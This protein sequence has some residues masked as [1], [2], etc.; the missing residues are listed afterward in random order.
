MLSRVAY[1][2]CCMIELTCKDCG[3]VEKVEEYCPYTGH[4]YGE[5]FEY[6]CSKCGGRL[7]EEK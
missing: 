6:K 7:T 4:R 2:G 1:K 5:G 3:H